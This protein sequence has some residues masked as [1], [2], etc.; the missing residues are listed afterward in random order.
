LAAAAQA[1]AALWDAVAGVFVR[2]ADAVAA[3]TMVGSRRQV[4]PTGL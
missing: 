2:P 1:L 3:G 4:A